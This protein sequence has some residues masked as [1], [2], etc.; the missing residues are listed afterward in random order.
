MFVLVTELPVLSPLICS[1]IQ[2]LEHWEEVLQEKMELFESQPK[3]Y[4]PNCYVDNTVA[5]ESPAINKY[6]AMFESHNTPFKYVHQISYCLQSIIQIS[7]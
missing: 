6:K 3:N 7:Y 1:V 2:T 4:M 5:Q